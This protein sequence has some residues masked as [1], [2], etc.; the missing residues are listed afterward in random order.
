V[1]ARF[2]STDRVVIYTRAELMQC[3]HWRHAFAAE[4]KDHRYYELIEDTIQADFNYG[5]FAIENGSGNVSAIQPF[6]VL[7][8]DLLVGI[9][10]KLKSLIRHLRRLF[11]LH[12]NAH[13]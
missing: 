10:S 7:D 3:P 6:F 11:P 9:G 4:R 12:A 2:A 1:S 13:G 5:Y 8:Q